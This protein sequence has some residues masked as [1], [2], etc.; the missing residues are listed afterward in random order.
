MVSWPINSLIFFGLKLIF[1]SSWISLGANLLQ[2][3]TS[4]IYK[5]PNVV[6]E[7]LNE[8]SL[9]LEK[10]GFENISELVGKNVSY[11]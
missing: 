7:I 11:E 5:G 2:L 8:L 10:K 6:F 3:Y 1:L 4:L 9:L